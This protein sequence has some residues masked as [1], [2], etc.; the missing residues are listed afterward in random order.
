[1]LQYPK[2][3]LCTSLQA[4]GWMA[5]EKSEFVM[6]SPS[7]IRTARSGPDLAAQIQDG[8]LITNSGFFDHPTTCVQASYVPEL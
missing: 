2:K 4:G 7:W 6:R 3:Q 8:D 1:M 5:E